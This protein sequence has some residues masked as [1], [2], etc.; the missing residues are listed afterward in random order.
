[1]IGRKKSVEMRWGQGYLKKLFSD[2]PRVTG[3]RRT[4]SSNSSS[5]YLR[6]RRSLRNRMTAYLPQAKPLPASSNLGVTGV[7]TMCLP[8]LSCSSAADC[9]PAAEIMRR[10]EIGPPC[11]TPKSPVVATQAQDILHCCKTL[12]CNLRP[13][14]NMNKVPKEY[15]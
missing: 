13:N 5:T 4:T 6:R 12:A 3:D 2:S 10:S 14:E 9:G 1:M 11:F 15:Y 8:W 7:H